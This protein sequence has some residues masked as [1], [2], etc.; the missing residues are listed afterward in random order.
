MSAYLIP[1]VLGV[2]IV[3]LLLVLRCTR[4][5]LEEM[6]GLGKVMEPGQDD[7]V[8]GSFGS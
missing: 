4:K 7:D 5:K 8:I 6:D 3:V 1:V 2:L